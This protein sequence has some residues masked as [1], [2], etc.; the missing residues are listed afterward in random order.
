MYGWNYRQ[1]WD[2]GSTEAGLFGSAWRSQ[3]ELPRGE[4]TF[5]LQLEGEVGIHEQRTGVRWQH[6]RQR[7]KHEGS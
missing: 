7:E 1:L 2:Q 4:V 6:P 5:E 3:G